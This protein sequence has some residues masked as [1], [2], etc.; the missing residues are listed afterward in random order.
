[1]PRQRTS[2]GARLVSLTTVDGVSAK[3]TYS[4][5]ARWPVTDNTKLLIL[6]LVLG[7]RRIEWSTFLMR[8][9]GGAPV[10]C[11]CVPSSGSLS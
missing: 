6:A 10:I 4:P 5:A 7:Q 2:V 11:A 1:M 8:S 9:L 3:Q